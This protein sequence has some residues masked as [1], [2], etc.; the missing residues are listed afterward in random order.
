MVKGANKPD[1]IAGYCELTGNYCLVDN[2]DAGR[3]EYYNTQEELDEATVQA[4]GCG[5]TVKCVDSI[6]DEA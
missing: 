1:F 6:H 5:H 3:Y 4:E 2:H